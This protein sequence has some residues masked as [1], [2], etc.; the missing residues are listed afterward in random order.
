MNP[1]N[2]FIEIVSLALV[3]ALV[4]VVIWPAMRDKM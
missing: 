1:F 2:L 4:V 3:A